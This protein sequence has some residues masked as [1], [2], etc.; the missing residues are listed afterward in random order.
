M[1]C[2]SLPAP[3]EHPRPQGLTGGP[4]LPVKAPGPAKRPPGQRASCGTG[5]STSDHHL[6]TAPGGYQPRTISQTATLPWDPGMQAWLPIRAR[7]YKEWPLDSSCKDWEPDAYKSS[8]GGIPGSRGGGQRAKTVA[9]RPL[10]SPLREPAGP[11]MPVR[12]DACPQANSKT[13]TWASLSQ[14]PSTLPLPYTLIF[15][16]GASQDRN[17]LRA[18]FSPIASWGLWTEPYWFS[19]LDVLAAHLLDADLK[20]GG[21]PL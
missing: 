19:K 18:H 15:Q 7:Q 17:P 11:Q 13:S 14:S 10:T 3:R 2:T 20:S 4:V 16:A 21:F 12:S 6:C 5:G 9:T 1:L 8:T